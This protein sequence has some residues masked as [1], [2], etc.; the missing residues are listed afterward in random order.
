MTRLLEVF[1]LAASDRVVLD[2][3]GPGTALELT[4]DPNCGSGSLELFICLAIIC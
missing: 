4:G 3:G 1:S 2:C